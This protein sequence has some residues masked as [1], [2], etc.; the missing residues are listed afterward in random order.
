LLCGSPAI[1]LFIY[2]S[3][4][5]RCCPWRIRLVVA[6]RC[7]ALA[8]RFC[9][10]N[11]WLP[12]AFAGRSRTGRLRLDHST[13]RPLLSLGDLLVHSLGGTIAPEQVTVGSPA[14]VVPDR[15]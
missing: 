6:A 8:A 7:A 14:L 1:L 9:A 2:V 10:L 3:P 11:T 5:W 12:T 13:P 4:A 15:R